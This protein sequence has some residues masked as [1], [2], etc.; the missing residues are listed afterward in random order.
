MTNNAGHGLFE[1]FKNA[2][3]DQ[4]HQA[5]LKAAAS[6]D[7]SFPKFSHVAIL[8]SAD[9]KSGIDEAMNLYRIARPHLDDCVGANKTY[10]DFGCGVGRIMK[11][12]MRDFPAE[13]MIGID[14]MEDFIG[15][16]KADFGDKFR[17]NHI[18]FRPPT[19]IPDNSVDVITA[20]SVFSHFSAI[21]ATRWLNEFNRIARP[22]ATIILTTYGRG[23]INYLCDTPYENL[24]KAKQH[25]ADF[26]NENGGKSEI[27]RMFELGEM[28]YSIQGNIFG[29]YDYGHA[30]VGEEFARRVWGKNF[31]VLEVVDDFKKLEQ[32]AVVLRKRK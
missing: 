22:G 6:K 12:Y 20:Y 30:Y 17:F 32:M 29:R 28:I 3:I 7:P 16:C 13:N 24:L 25:Q 10:L 31:E 26:V 4:W 18:G 21:Q 27:F 5:L 23:H 15:T 19:N 8:G 11:T 2:S 14:P 1:K 9:V